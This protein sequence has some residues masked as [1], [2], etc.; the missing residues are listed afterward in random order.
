MRSSWW[1]VVLMVAGALG[2]FTATASAQWGPGISHRRDPHC[3]RYVPYQEPG[4]GPAGVSN[5]PGG[6][7]QAFQPYDRPVVSGYYANGGC[8]PCRPRPI[9]NFFR[10]VFGC[11]N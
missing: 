10:A 5:Y 3:G 9:R 4:W 2:L 8:E 11:R 7:P 1:L 6:Y